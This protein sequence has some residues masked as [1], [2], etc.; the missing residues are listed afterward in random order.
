MRN[1]KVAHILN[2]IVVDVSTMFDA[3]EDYVNY[4]NDTT[5]YYSCMHSVGKILTHEIEH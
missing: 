3:R 1:E 4:S 2:E 5:Y